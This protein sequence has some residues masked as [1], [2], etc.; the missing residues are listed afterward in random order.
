[1]KTIVAL[2]VLILLTG[3]S[4]VPEPLVFENSR[5]YNKSR[6]AVWKKLLTFFD[7]SSIRIVTQ[8]RVNGILTAKRNLI[9]GSIYVYCKTDDFSSIEDGLLTVKISLQSLAENRT[10]ATIEV[11]L[12]GNLIYFGM[13]KTAIECSSNGALEKEILKNL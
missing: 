5:T 2:V 9:R 11:S 4:T 3:C 10:R 1:M 12:S 6:P 13:T 7:S 8:D